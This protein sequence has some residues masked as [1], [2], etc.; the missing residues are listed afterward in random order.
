MF[1]AKHKI[2]SEF[3]L[4]NKMVIT[5]DCKRSL[6]ELGTKN[7]NVGGKNYSYELTHNELM[8]TVDTTE[9]LINKTVEFTA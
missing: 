5:L 8:F 6:D 9:S 7:I 1:M 2:V 3:R 4:K